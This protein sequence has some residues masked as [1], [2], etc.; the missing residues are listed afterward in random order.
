MDWAVTVIVAVA[1]VGVFM[2]LARKRASK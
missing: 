2:A 1:A